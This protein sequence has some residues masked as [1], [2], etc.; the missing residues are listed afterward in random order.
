[1]LSTVAVQPSRRAE[2]RADLPSLLFLAVVAVNTIVLATT[3]HLWL[4]AL[5]ALPQALL[6]AGCQEAKHMAVHGTFLS[7]RRANDAV[8]VVFA[9][10]FGVNFTAYRYFHL[11]HHRATCTEA[12]PEGQLYALSWRTRWIWALAPL[13]LPW[14]AWHQNRVGWPMVPASRRGERNAAVVW[15]LV[16]FAIV[17]FCA[18]HAPQA[19]LWVYAIPAALLSWFDFMLTQAEHYGVP[20]GAALARRDPGETTQ[21][22]VLPF[23]L[24]WLMLH[25]PLHR[26]HHRYPGSRWYEAPRRLRDDPTA[27]PINYA[28]FVRRWLASGPRLWLLENS[29]PATHAAPVK[30]H[31]RHTHEP[32]HVLDRT[33]E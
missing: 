29:A 32:L 15:M 14:I 28:A 17:G 12:D 4:R 27:A 9:A 24:G 16:F 20:I 25:R 3:S 1:M 31:R 13:E 22:I 19:V 26:V 11:Q 21:D 7:E 23:G 8:G 2:L 30:H 18:W 6:L 10:L 5:L 33:A